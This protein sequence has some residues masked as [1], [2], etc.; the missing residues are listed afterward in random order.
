MDEI[1]R[2]YAKKPIVKISN[3]SLRIQRKKSS[4]QLKSPADRILFLQRTIGNQA[5]QRM[6]RSGA[7]QA[8]L[9]IG[10]PGDKYEQEADRMADA[11][12]RMP[13]PGVQREVEPEEEEMLQTKPLAG[14]ITPL[15]QVQRQEEPEEDEEELQAKATSGRISEVNPNLESHIQS[16]KGGG[17]PLP[18]SERAY[19]EPR[20][21]QDFSQVRVHSDAQ[22]ARAVNARAFTVGKDVIFGAGQYSPGTRE[23]QRLMAHELTHVVQQSSHSQRI[24]RYTEYSS[25]NQAAGSSLGWVHPGATDIRVADSGLMVVEDKGWNP[26]SNKRAWT[27]KSKIAESNKIL[28]NIGSNAKLAEKGG[29]ISGKPPSNAVQ[30]T[31]TL[32]EIEPIK[33]AGAGAFSLTSDCGGAARQVMGSDGGK[34]VAVTRKGSVESYTPAESYHGGAKTTP[35]V[36]FE[37]IL[38][39][40]FGAGHTR[41]VLYDKYS[42]LSAAKKDTFDK[43]Y[44]INKYAAP[45]VGQGQTISSEFDMPGFATVPGVSTWNFHYAATVLKSGA[46][47]VTLESAAGWGATDWIFYMY[48]PA[49]KAQS[50]HEEHGA[51]D[52]HGTHYTTMVVQPEKRLKG[53]TSA[54]GVHLVANPNKWDT[55]LIVK[56]AKGTEVY[57]IKKGNNWRKVEVK[58]GPDTGKIGWISNAYFKEK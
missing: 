30:P 14:Q 18:K 23:G 44:K 19:F 6:V 33:A 41:T 35:E 42:K 27:T 10:Q 26:G 49:K 43:K 58:T 34:D 51:M 39:R 17:K 13:E 25:A 55:T 12:M 54:A 40:E 4:Q 7:L 5:V 11:V 24:Q 47:H 29:T 50:F 45:Q 21:G 2:L 31:R 56:L 3:S 1:S 8:K 20:F 53:K 32:V 48:G 28:K 15:V 16:L 57:T 9:K 22:A 36:F 46:D 37:E 38:K 52:S